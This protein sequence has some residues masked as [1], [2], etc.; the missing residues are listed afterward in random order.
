LNKRLLGNS[1]AKKALKL[2]FILAEAAVLL[3]NAVNEFSFTLILSKAVLT[4]TENCVFTVR[5]ES[6]L[7]DICAN[8]RFRVF[9]I[10]AIAGNK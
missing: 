10:A 6:T 9:S 2:L 5:V 3:V 7:D 8:L 4:T 1:T